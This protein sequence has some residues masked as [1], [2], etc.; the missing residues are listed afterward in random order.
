MS[1]IRPNKEQFLELIE[2]ARRR[3]GRDAQPAEVQGS[4]D[5]GASAQRVRQVRRLV[6][7]MVEARGGKVLWMGKADQV[8]IG[9]V[10]ANDW[11]AV[12]LVQYPSRKAFIDMVTSTGV[13]RRRTSTASRASSAPC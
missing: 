3:A 10:D 1:G 12:A 5:G 11:D 8:L 9:D 13:R 6:V 7:Q 2:R 4:G